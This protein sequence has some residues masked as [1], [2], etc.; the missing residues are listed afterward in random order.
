MFAYKEFEGVRH[1]WDIY[2]DSWITEEYWEWVND[3]ARY[4]AE[5]SPVRTYDPES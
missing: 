1:V 5:E 4:E 3:H 2:T